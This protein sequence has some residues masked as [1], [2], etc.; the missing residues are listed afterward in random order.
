MAGF[1]VTRLRLVFAC[2]PE[3]CSASLSV[4]FGFMEDSSPKEREKSDSASRQCA[5]WSAPRTGCRSEARTQRHRPC[6]FPSSR[7]RSSRCSSLSSSTDGRAANSCRRLEES[8]AWTAAD[9]SASWRK[10]FVAACVTTPNFTVPFLDVLAFDSLGSR[11]MAN[12]GLRSVSYNELI[13]TSGRHP[14]GTGSP[15]T[16]DFHHASIGGIVG[17]GTA[18]ACPAAS[19]APS[20]PTS[21]GSSRCN[22]FGRVATNRHPHRAHRPV[23]PCRRQATWVDLLGTH[24]RASNFWASCVSWSVGRIT[25]CATEHATNGPGVAEDERSG[26]VAESE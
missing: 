18:I 6:R 24:R 25:D 19:C 15:T 10:W 14:N 9:S 13:G 7:R 26:D 11:P 21:A 12:D 23:T 20:L 5:R 4:V 22:R 16:N 8:L 3:S 2:G 1:A 17:F